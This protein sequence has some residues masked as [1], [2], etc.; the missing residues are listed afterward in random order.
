M[1]YRH[2]SR[3]SRT[4]ERD[5]VVCLDGHSDGRRGGGVVWRLAVGAEEEPGVVV[6][7]G[8]A[9]DVRVYG[10]GGAPVDE[11]DL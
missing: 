4:A 5:R 9:C 2:R 1:R 11:L 7:E 8:Q 10:G 6:V 3:T